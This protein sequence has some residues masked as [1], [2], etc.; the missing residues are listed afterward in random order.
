MKYIVVDLEMNPIAKS[1]KEQ[2]KQ[3]RKEIIQIGAV[4]LDRQPSL[5]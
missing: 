2:R 3:C 1:Y 4:A 5:E